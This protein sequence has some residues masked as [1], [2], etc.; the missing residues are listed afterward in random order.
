MNEI[1]PGVYHWTTFHEGIGQPV[2]SYYVH[3]ADPPF[4]IDP[5]VP[6][7]EGLE[8]FAAM[9]P[10]HN[11][12]LTNRHHYRHSARFANRFGIDAWCQRDGLH[13]FT[14]GEHVRPFSHGEEL[15][16]GVLALKVAAL[17]PEETALLIP[18]HGGLLSLGDA[19]I[20]SEAGLSFVPDS[21]MGRDSK[22]V[23]RG[24]R[25]ALARIIEQQFFHYLLLAHGDP[26]L[27][28]GKEVLTRFI[29]EQSPS[30]P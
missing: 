16:G 21:L 12:Y 28:N 20:R 9:G 13:A 23:K 11:I 17:C 8:W 2:H 27:E 25:Q 30:P 1:L 22:T 14:R 26:V 7:E 15:P 5:R 29:E 19:V 24:L 6:D 18:V 10:P 3:G 4:L